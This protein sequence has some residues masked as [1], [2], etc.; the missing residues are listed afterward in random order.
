MEVL[1]RGKDII[2]NPK[3]HKR[4][5]IWLHGLGDSA[6]GF[7]PL[8][9]MN[10]LLEDCKIVLLTAPSRP[11]TLNYGM[12]MNSWY[13]IISIDKREMNPEVIE[14]ADRVSSEIQDQRKSTKE[15]YLGGFSQGGALSLYTGL[16]HIDIPLH[17]I[18]GVSC[19]A[20]NYT[21][22]KSLANTPIMLY[23]GKNDGMVPFNMA[24]ESFIN[25]LVDV[26]YKLY[27]EDGLDHG[28]SMGTL[29]SI[30][31]WAKGLYIKE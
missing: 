16:V 26:K 3:V 13:D 2:L 15:I 9:Q 10:P 18:I 5:L 12:K 22:K 8:F 24:K 7:L 25:V 14:S 6:E 19:Y 31:E 29:N 21:I 11:V 4:T 1:R 20:M 28:I 23:H 27:S 30:S 17:A